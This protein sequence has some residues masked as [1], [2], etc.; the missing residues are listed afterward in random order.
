VE[1]RRRLEAAAY[2]RRRADQEEHN[3][4]R[5]LKGQ[6]GEALLPSLVTPLVEV[7][8]LALLDRAL[9]DT[10]ANIDCLIVGTSGVVIIDA[11]N[12][13]GTLSIEGRTLRQSGHSRSRAVESL[14]R[15]A[16]TVGEI[17]DQVGGDRPPVIPVMCFVG[18]AAIG[19]SRSL[20]RVRLLDQAHLIDFVSAL[21]V[22]MESP[23]A[24]AV[25]AA[26]APRLPLRQPT[27]AP[28]ET[29][30]PAETLVF[31]EPWHKF[32]H[33]RLY[34][35]DG[36]G[37]ELGHLDL[38]SGNVTVTDPDSGGMLARLLPH[39]AYPGDVS[40]NLSEEAQR[41]LKR[42]LKSIIG[43]KMDPP[44]QAL[45]A[46]YHWR[47]HGKNRLYL[48]RLQPGGNKTELG[49]FDL[50]GRRPSNPNA[51]PLLSYCGQ[52]FL[53]TARTPQDG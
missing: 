37:V 9:P 22:A 11:K 43:R 31:L 34:V 23:Q 17:L 29:E 1:S 48:S 6:T 42:F 53:A 21:P 41:G 32:S 8:Y 24:E 46:A 45:I 33:H 26:L 30:A 47:G 40:E 16:V 19:D 51:A 20:E 35:K 14:R 12:W 28:V 39:Y 52:R 10:D 2:H 5:W 25:F 7:G 18:A 3:A 36:D 38:A 27:L 4:A 49:W 50:D 15:Q 13:D 44:Q